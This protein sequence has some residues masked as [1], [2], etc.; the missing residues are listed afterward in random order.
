MRTRVGSQRHSKKKGGLFEDY[1][2][3]DMKLILCVQTLLVLQSDGINVLRIVVIILL[4]LQYG[5]R[6][7]N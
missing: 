1:R 6:N 3:T 2:E 5:L 4:C 7:I